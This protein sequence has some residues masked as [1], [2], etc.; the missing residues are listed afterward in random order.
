MCLRG[1]GRVGLERGG[2]VPGQ[3]LFDAVDR[4]FG[5]RCQDRAQVEGRIEP[6]Q[7]GCT[8][9][10]VERCRSL[11]AGISSHE[12]VILPSDGDSPDILPMSVRNLRFTIV[13]TRSLGGKFA[14]EI[15]NSA[16]VGVS[17][18]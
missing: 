6:A 18:T 4:M 15:A 11:T 2:D 17:C 3:E 9:E 5:D 16:A 8:D 1:L 14:I 13:G 12:E 7:F 10:A